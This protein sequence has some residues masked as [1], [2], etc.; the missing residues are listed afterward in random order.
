MWKCLFFSILFPLLVATQ[1]TQAQQPTLPNDPVATFSGPNMAF[2][3]PNASR[4]PS[5]NAM[6]EQDAIEAS[7]TLGNAAQEIVAVPLLT[8]LSQAIWIDSADKPAEQTH[9]AQVAAMMQTPSQLPPLDLGVSSAVDARGFVGT[10]DAGQR[11]FDVGVD[12]YSA[13]DFDGGLIVFGRN[14]AMKLG[15]YVKA[16]FIYDFDPIDSTDSFDTSSIPVG[17]PPRTNTRAHAR[18]SRLSFDFPP[19]QARNRGYRPPGRP[20]ASRTSTF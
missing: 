19:V 18:Q 5:V 1:A 14:V 6:I 16:D 3:S 12:L 13:P 2:A 17:V 11:A 15:G 10:F 8:L 20:A 7:F 9:L 4:S